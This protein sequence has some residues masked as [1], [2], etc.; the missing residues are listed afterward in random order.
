MVIK[1]LCHLLALMTHLIIPSTRW[2]H[3]WLFHPQEKKCFWLTLSCNSGHGKY[4][5]RKNATDET[6]DRLSIFHIGWIQCMNHCQLS[7]PFFLVI[8]LFFYCCICY[9][10]CLL[11]M[12]YPSVVVE[13]CWACVSLCWLLQQLMWMTIIKLYLYC[14]HPCIV[15]ETGRVVTVSFLSCKYT[16]GMHVILKQWSSLI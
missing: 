5:K 12:L 14:K 15:G 16:G 4:K 11:C 7:L 3:T 2:W 6:Y 10:S 8:V 9:F 13:Q 1:H